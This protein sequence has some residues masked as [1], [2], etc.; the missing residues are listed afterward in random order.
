[1]R[2]TTGLK[3]FL[4]V[5]AIAVAL[6]V[7]LL[8]YGRSSRNDG[9][10]PDQAAVPAPSPPVAAAPP[11]EPPAPPPAA[12]HPPGPDQSPS[13]HAPPPPAGSE[14]TKPLSESVL[15]ARLRQVAG[16]DYPL[17]VD[18]AR[19]GNR[20]FPDSPDAPERASI[21]IHA[22]A[23]QGMAKEARGEA[24]YAVNHYPDSQWVRD[25][26]GFTGAHRHRNLILTDG[27][28][29]QTQ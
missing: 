10:S 4:A 19:A 1:V 13:T 7:A 3:I 16:S 25:I 5:A 2:Q 22:L 26:E 8:T 23:A 17:A 18:L 12:P 29:I 11:P 24:E 28:T 9:P 14:A 6:A 20:R 21:L 27:G 15:M